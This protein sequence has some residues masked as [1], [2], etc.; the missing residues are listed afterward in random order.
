MHL[1]W[2]LLLEDDEGARDLDGRAFKPTQLLVGVLSPV[3]A[4][5]ASDEGLAIDTLDLG[6]DHDGEHIPS[7][8][9]ARD[10]RLVRVL[11][12]RLQS[13]YFR[14]LQKL[15]DAVPSAEAVLKFLRKLAADVTSHTSLFF[16]R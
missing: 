6:S 12:Q 4:A 10:A 1:D 7:W 15:S 13:H 14:W 8:L 2:V 11:V 16:P 5:V 9:D 3:F